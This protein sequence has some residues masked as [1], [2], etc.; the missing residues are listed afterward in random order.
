M[1]KR[2]NLSKSRIM[3]AQQCPKLLYLDV[4]HRDLKEISPSTQAAFDTGH[5]VGDIAQEIYGGGQGTFI[6]YGPGLRQAIIDTQALMENGP[7]APIY[8]ATYE[9][10]GV[11][12][13]ADVQ[14]P[15]GDGWRIIEVKSST[16][17]K[18]E[19]IKDS[20]IQAWVFKNLGYKLEGI[21]LA[22]IDNQF[23]YQ[24]DGDYSGLLVENDIADEVE[25]LLPQVPEWIRTA[26]QAISGEMP[27]VPVGGH[28]SKPYP[29]SFLKQCWP[30]DVDYPVTGLGGG[31]KSLAELVSEGYRDIRDVPAERISGARQRIHRVTLSGEPELL[32]GAREFVESLGYPRYYLDFETIAA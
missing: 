3:S 26:Q 14:L 9:Y 12:V 31:K 17:L 11:L 21:A 24:G 6:E 18:E 23:L 10:E 30:S 16:K 4:H 22:H 2:T 5:L 8:E 15:A 28:C 25:A 7:V 29:C 1:P 20:A 19:H 32:P 13:R 27:E